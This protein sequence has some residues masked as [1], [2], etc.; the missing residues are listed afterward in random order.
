[1]SLTVF[2]DDL[3]KEPLTM[4]RLKFVWDKSNIK[5]KSPLIDTLSNAL[6]KQFE[7]KSV[8][9][10]E[11]TL[12]MCNI[13]RNKLIKQ[14]IVSTN[15]HLE[16]L[17]VSFKNPDYQDCKIN[18]PTGMLFREKIIKDIKKLV[19]IGVYASDKVYP[20]QLKH[21]NICISNGWY[22]ENDNPDITSVFKI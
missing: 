11:E 20:L 5:N 12:K 6:Y 18:P 14:K 3:T 9:T 1:M 10:P 2:I 8:Y 15:P 19:V 4:D 17:P 7:K 13:F 22:F 21:L 16:S